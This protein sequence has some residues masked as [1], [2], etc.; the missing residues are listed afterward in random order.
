VIDE[1]TGRVMNLDKLPNL[2]IIIAS[3]VNP[4]AKNWLKLMVS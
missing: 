3:G 2:K 4:D 1:E